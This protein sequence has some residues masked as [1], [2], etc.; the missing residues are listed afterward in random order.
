MD[1]VKLDFQVRF[2]S[3]NTLVSV[4]FCTVLETNLKVIIKN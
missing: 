1:A 3:F 4:S 2:N